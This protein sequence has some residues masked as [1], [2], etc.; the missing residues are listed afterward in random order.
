MAGRYQESR[1]AFEEG[2]SDEEGEDLEPSALAL[3][4]ERWMGD[5]MF[6]I[7]PC[8]AAMACGRR[9]INALFVQEG[10]PR[11]TRTEPANSHL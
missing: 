4:K 5:A 10:E 6:G 8:L 3:V 2:R 1:S 9:T 11:S 7:G